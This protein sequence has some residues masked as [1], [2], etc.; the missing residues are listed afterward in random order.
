LSSLLSN[1]VKKGWKKVEFGD[2][3]PSSKSSGYGIY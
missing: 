3:P 2:S 1:Y